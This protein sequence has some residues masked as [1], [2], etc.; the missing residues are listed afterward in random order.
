MVFAGSATYAPNYDAAQFLVRD[1]YPSIRKTE[2]GATLQ[3]TGALPGPDRPLPEASGVRFTGHVRDIRPLIAQS[4]VSVVPLRL[5]GGT[6]LKI[7]E[8]MAIGTPV[9]ATSKGAEGL[10]VRDG[11]NILVADEPGLFAQRVLSVLASGEL[12]E[13]L[14]IG[15][16]D[17]VRSTYDWG[18]VGARLDA[19]IREA[20]NGSSTRHLTKESPGN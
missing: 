7:L 15:G 1:I 5:G 4:W 6:R 10:D 3:I 9:V 12:R 16:S 14:A 13:K 2:P 18:I 11:V 8:S 20:A 17:L 19:V